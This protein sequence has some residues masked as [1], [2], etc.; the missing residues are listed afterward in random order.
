MVFFAYG[1]TAVD[2]AGANCRVISDPGSPSPDNENLELLANCK[3][4]PAEV[5]QWV[6]QRKERLCR[7]LAEDARLW[8]CPEHR[9]DWN[10]SLGIEQ[11][12]LSQCYG[13]RDA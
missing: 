7:E 13:I 10:V 6:R 3:L 4:T 12:T 5:L 8:T 11:L 9:R 1:G 2:L